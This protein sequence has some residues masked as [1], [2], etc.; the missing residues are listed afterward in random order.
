M[1][2]KSF[3]VGCMAA[4]LLVLGAIGLL[5]FVVDPFWYFRVVEVKGFNLDKPRAGGSERLVKPPLAVKMQPEAVIVGSSFAEIGLPP[6]H[7]GFTEHGAYSSFNLSLHGIGWDD[8]YCLARFAI[9]RAH[10][11]RL[12]VTIQGSRGANCPSEIEFGRVDYGKLLFSRNALDASLATLRAQDGRPYMTR[13]GLWYLARYEDDMQS[14]DAVAGH[15]ASELRDALCPSARGHSRAD[16]RLIINKSPTAPEQGAGL[17][18]LIRLAIEKK[19]DLVLLFNPTHVL[20]NEMARRC[21]G[22]AAHWQFLWQVVSIVDQETEGHAALVSVWDF[23]AYRA[24][25]G[26]PMH[27]GKPMRERLWQDAGHY[28]HEVGSR[29]F[30]A[31]YSGAEGFGSRVTVRNFDQ[32]VARTEDERRAFLADNSW[33]GPEIDEIF[34]RA[35]GAVAGAGR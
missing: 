29:A 8:I 33:V 19:V 16:D 21:D 7:P 13:E 30:D 10:V 26:E 5:N 17:R 34:A 22:P 12:V 2:F 9:D 4:I 25:N 27:A 18:Q 6:T 24:I 11:K 32:F 35:G 28:N 1:S 20:F 15:F 31:I 23:Y 14:D 3:S